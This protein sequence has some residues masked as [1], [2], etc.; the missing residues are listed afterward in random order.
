MPSR[1]PFGYQPWNQNRTFEVRLL[2]Q[3]RILRQLIRS[4][5][6]LTRWRQILWLCKR[7]RFSAKTCG[8]TWF[9]CRAGT[10]T[11]AFPSTRKVRNRL[12]MVI[13]VRLT[14]YRIFW[15]GY[16]HTELQVLSHP[17]RGRHHR[18]SLPAKL[19][20]QVSRSSGRPTNR[21]ISET[22][23]TLRLH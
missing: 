6:C 4:R 8:T 17:C 21:R 22:W 2:L 7:P 13:G 14:S 19:V 18:C 15:S 12:P 20:H 3:H 11:S 9:W 1:N 10:S 5:Q 16:I 23:T